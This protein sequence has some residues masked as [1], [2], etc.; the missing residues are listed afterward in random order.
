VNAAAPLVLTM[1]EPGGVG[2]E[3][4]V[5]AWRALAATGPVF[6]AIDDPDRLSALGAPVRVI[7]QAREAA[8]AFAG[9]LPVLPLGSRIMARP[10]VADPSL[11]R[12]VI[13]SIE[14][15]VGAALAGESAGVVTSPISKAS[16]LAAGFSHPGHTEFLGALA[17]AAPLP[18]P[19]RT[20]GPAMML[21]G[22]S[23]RTLPVTVHVP[24]AAAAK[25]LSTGAIVRAGRIAAE[26]L[27]FDFGVA[28]PRLAVAGLNPHAGEGGALGMEDDAVIAPAV[29]ALRA[30]GIDAKGPLSAD[31][32]FHEDARTR[33]DAALCMYHDQA[34]IPVK[35]LAFH[36]TVNVTLG[37]PFVRTSPDHGTALDIAGKGV[38]RPDSLIAAIRLAA[39]IAG[40]R[41]AQ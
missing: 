19:L 13:D 22:P 30:E 11:A 26:A 5:K 1:G 23:L 17:A 27:A 33:Y 20:R 36:D 37:L 41:A 40:R 15:A 29:A 21:C 10:G 31:T 39:E 34:L 2:G 8:G 35:T 32:L 16:L 7:A 4:A 28:A 18:V 9:A 3:I 24:L 38:A 14:R 6:Y 12:A 25:S